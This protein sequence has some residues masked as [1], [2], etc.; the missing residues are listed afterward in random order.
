M[1]SKNAASACRYPRQLTSASED[2]KE[3]IRGSKEPERRLTGWPTAPQIIQTWIRYVTAYLNVIAIQMVNKVDF[4]AEQQAGNMEQISGALNIIIKEVRA[5]AAPKDGQSIFRLPLC[6][7]EAFDN[8]LKG[9]T[10]PTLDNLDDFLRICN[11]DYCLQILLMI[12]AGS[13]GFASLVMGYAVSKG[14]IS[15]IISRTL[16]SSICFD[17]V[18]YDEFILSH[19]HRCL[20]TVAAHRT[21][22]PIKP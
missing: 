15:M 5:R 10:L 1:T 9:L 3:F 18:V 8:F 21:A 13:D 22:P 4:M 16:L 17:H 2:E 20:Y 7:E 11:P 14:R 12:E 19:L 6:T